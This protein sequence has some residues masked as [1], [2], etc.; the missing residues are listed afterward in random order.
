[1]PNRRRRHRACGAALGAGAAAA[2][3]RGIANRLGVHI[4]AIRRLTKAEATL[5]FGVFRPVGHVVVA[6][7]NDATTTD[8]ARALREQGFEAQDVLQYS[9]SEESATMRDMLDHASDFAGFGYEVTLMRRYQELARQG[10]GWLVVYAPDD[11]H[12]ARITAVAQQYRARL[13]ERYHRLLIEDL[14]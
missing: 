14:I 7:D 12:A 2:Y 10:C 9:A 8:A 11:D 1:M 4:M 6:F 5:S 3:A 13:A